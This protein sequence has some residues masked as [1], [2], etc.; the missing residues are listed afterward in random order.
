MWNEIAEL[1]AHHGH[2]SVDLQMLKITEEVGEAA[3][4]YIGMIGANKRKGVHRT[5]EDVLAELSDV[6]I[7]AA[8]AMSRLTGGDQAAAAGA[9]DSRLAHVLSR[10]DG[11]PGPGGATPT[12]S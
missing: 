2:V 1:H 8:V 10:L 3:E 4:A 9:L 5:R 12:A 6:I 11:P 7:T